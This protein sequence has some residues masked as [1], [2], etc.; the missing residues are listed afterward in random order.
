MTTIDFTAEVEKRKDAMLEDLFELL[1]IDSAMDMDNADKENP[2]GPGPRKALDKFL[3]WLN[4]MATK[5]KT[6]ITMLVT[7]NTE[8][9]MKF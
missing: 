5:L 9:V 8:K 1:R 2:F 3:N 7:L 4:V 6:M